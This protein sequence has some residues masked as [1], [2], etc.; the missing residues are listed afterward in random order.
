M[1]VFYGCKYT[2]FCAHDKANQ[3]CSVSNPAIMSRGL[4]YVAKKY[5]AKCGFGTPLAEED[6]ANS[7]K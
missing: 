6:I 1:F 7:K 3:A 4:C 2:P 5:R